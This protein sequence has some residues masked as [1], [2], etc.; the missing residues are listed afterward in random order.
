MILRSLRGHPEI[1]QSSSYSV[2]VSYHPAN[3]HPGSHSPNSSLQSEENPTLV[4]RTQKQQ[5]T[6]QV[7]NEYDLYFKAKK[8][9]FLL[10]T[11]PGNP[12]S[13]R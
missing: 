7:R 10:P 13:E 9:I 3:G 2:D 11:P 4:S 12:L 8:E 1:A 6:Q 5:T